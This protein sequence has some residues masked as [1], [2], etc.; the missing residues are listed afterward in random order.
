M[1]PCAHLTNARL[2][3]GKLLSLSVR[4]SL[5]DVICHDSSHFLWCIFVLRDYLRLKK[6]IPTFNEVI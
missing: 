3:G 5:L 2:L 6:L 1:L 4:E